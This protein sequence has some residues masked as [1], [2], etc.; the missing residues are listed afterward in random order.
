MISVAIQAGGE[1]RRMG[2][3]KALMPFLGMTLLEW[4]MKRVSSLGDELFVTTNHP[5]KYQD[6]GV[7]LYQDVL[8]GMGAL[9]GLLT[10]L[11]SAQNP[12]LIVIACDMPFANID[13]LTLAI[14]RL[15]SSNADVVIPRTKQG[16]EPFH[17]VYRLET[18][19]PAVQSALDA[20]ERRL[21]SWFQRVNILTIEER[22]LRKYDP[23]QIAFWNVNTEEE[24]LQAEKLASKL[25]G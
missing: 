15:Q 6:F 1:S 4:V 17:A 10:A 2:Q 24:F 9:G 20:G 19:L 25:N 14:E 11:S 8:P 23:H 22:E 5:E 13:L 7:P 3:D 12:V 18:C 21:I 16:Y